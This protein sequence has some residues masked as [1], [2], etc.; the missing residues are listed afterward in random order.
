[1]NR[2]STI[3]GAAAAAFAAVALAR[4]GAAAGPE[5]DFLNIL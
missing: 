4:S 2:T 5:E 3:V 1:M